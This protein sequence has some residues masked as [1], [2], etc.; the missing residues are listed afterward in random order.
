M[1]LLTSGDPIILKD[2]HFTNGTIEYD[3]EPLDPRFASFYFRWKNSKETECFYFRTERAG[4]P[5]A[6]DAVQY[7]PFLDGVNIWDMLFHFQTNAD[8]SKDVWNHVKLVISG[9]Q[10]RAYVNDMKSPVLEV[11][12]LEGNVAS[13]TLAFDGQAVIS[14]LEV[15]PDSTEGLS[16]E[17]GFD[18]TASDPR[19]LRKWQVS[20]PISTAPNIDFSYDYIPNDSMKWE[21][22]SAERHGLINLTRRFGGTVGRR[23]VW[24]KTA[25][26]SD[27]NQDKMLHFGFSDEVWVLINDKPLYVDK[28]LYNTPM[29]K[30]PDGR[31]SIENTSFKIPLKEGDNQLMVGVANFFYGWGIVAR[32]DDI[33]GIGLEQ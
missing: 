27:K 16:P 21:D 29:A 31:C 25:I 12:M 2:F 1:K 15:K 17:A 33:D 23:I 3:M 11:P 26:H 6:G 14:N 10:M 13:G 19:Y 22:L 24:L 20:V 30:L 8:F 32:L 9:K 4:N 7:A 28:N 18:P 5:Q